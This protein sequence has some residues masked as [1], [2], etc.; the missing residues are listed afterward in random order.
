MTSDMTIL[1]KCEAL[2]EQ[3]DAREARDLMEDYRAAHPQ[4]HVGHYLLG[5]ACYHLGEFEAADEAFSVSIGLDPDYENA[6]WTRLLILQRTASHERLIAYCVEYLKRFPGRVPVRNYLGLVY[7]KEQRWDDS[8]ACY[9]DSVARMPAGT[10][11]NFGGVVARI[12]LGRFDDA[13]GALLT[14]KASRP[15]FDPG[16]ADQLNKE[17]VVLAEKGQWAEAAG[18]FRAA[19]AAHIELDDAHYNLGVA[20]RELEAV[21]FSP[22]PPQN[23]AFRNLRDLYHVMGYYENQDPPW[24]VMRSSWQGVPIQK[25]PSDLTV[26]HQILWETKP[27]LIVECGTFQGGSALYYASLF[28][29]MG[30][31]RIVSVDLYL[32]AELPRHPRITYVAGSSTDP[33]VVGRV[34]GMAKPDDRVMVILDSDH[35]A[36]HVAGELEALHALVT[37]GCYLVVEDTTVDLSPVANTSYQNG[38]PLY[39]LADFIGR[40]PEFVID[41]RREQYL[42]TVAPYGFLYRMQAP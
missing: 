23:P 20:L 1:K 11:G 9:E 19:I 10:V 17:G 28:D 8:L 30:E 12:A 24:Q 14:A 26:Y 38:G 21:D 6:W 32:Q 31:G 15:R 5:L 39:A 2:I 36:S 18:A 3:G 7:G 40:H 34:R 16:L 13:A 22:P 37:P 25:F 33:D 27:T 41:R 35:S 29:M 4:D 42:T